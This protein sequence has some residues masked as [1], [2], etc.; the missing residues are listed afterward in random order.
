MARDVPDLAT[1]KQLAAG[2]NLIPVHRRLMS[3]QLTPVLAYRR[4]VRPDER[5]APSFL[6]ESVVGGERIGR[7]SYL[8]AVPMAE[9][10]GRGHEVEYRDHLDPSRCRRF[11][12][13]DPLGE[14]DLL[15]SSW[16]LAPV[17]ALPDFTG[18]WV[19]YAGYDIARH[20]ETFGT[21]PPDDRNLPDLLF[22]LYDQMVIFDHVRKLVHVVAHAHAGS[23]GDATVAYRTACARIEAHC[24]G[25]SIQFGTAICSASCSWM[26]TVG[27]PRCRRART[28]LTSCPKNG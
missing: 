3:D 19:G 26:I 12:S 7:Y 23:P 14:M 5:M 24:T 16:K 21:P 8:G 11:Q 6:L 27:S 15:T 28:T 4:L 25:S 13:D 10:I 18:G 22:G 2:A 17:P 20:Y 1:F 9:I